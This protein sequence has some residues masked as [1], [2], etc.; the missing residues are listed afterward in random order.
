MRSVSTSPEAL[1]VTMAEAQ[2]RSGLPRDLVRTLVASGE[3]LSIQR[4]RLRL[5]LWSSAEA[6]AHRATEGR[7]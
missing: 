6:W 5:V 4:G 2:R 7:P 3:W 1:F